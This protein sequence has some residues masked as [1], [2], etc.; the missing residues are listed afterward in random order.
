VR[1]NE[2]YYLSFL[3]FLREWE[4]ISF[5]ASKSSSST[6]EMQ[7]KHEKRELLIASHL[8]FTTTENTPKT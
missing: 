2:I 3:Y 1:I 6:H 8:D 5:I 4:R 7:F